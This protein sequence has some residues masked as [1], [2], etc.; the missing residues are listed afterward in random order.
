MGISAGKVIIHDTS[1]DT[2]LV[3]YRSEHPIFGNDVDLPGGTVEKN[4]TE[5]AATIR[6]VY[7]ETKISLKPETL[8]LLYSGTGYSRIN[9]KYILYSAK[10]SER[11]EVVLSWEHSKYEW[12]SKDDAIKQFRSTIDNFMRLAAD[13]LEKL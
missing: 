9:T 4:E 1:S 10:M 7:E 13:S 3:V 2:Y 8:T 5:L 11:P 12:L 6:E